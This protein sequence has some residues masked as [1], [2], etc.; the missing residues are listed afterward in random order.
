MAKKSN[1]KGSSVVIPWEIVEQDFKDMNEKLG[2]NNIKVKQAP[3]LIISAMCNSHIRALHCHS[4]NTEWLA[5]CK[6][7]P[8]WDWV[9]KL[10]DMIHPEQKTQAA[11]CEP[12]DDW[13]NW[14]V[15][16]LLEQKEKLWQWNCILHSHHHM[17]CFWSGTD[18]DARLGYNDWRNLMWAVV[19]AYDWEPETWN[20]KY[21]GCV[22]F[23]K[24]YNVEID[25]EI[26][27][28]E[29][30]YYK[31]C[32]EYDKSDSIKAKEIKELADS[33][34]EE[35]LWSQ[36]EALDNL[37]VKP[38]Y[39]KILDYLWID[40]TEELEENYKEV[41]K[42][43]PNK[44]LA[45]FYDGLYKEAYKTAE[46][47]IWNT[48]ATI[49]D[50][51]LEWKEWSDALIK[52]LDDHKKVEAY[53]YYWYKREKKDNKTVKTTQEPLIKSSYNYDYDDTYY[54][55]NDG[56]F[57]YNTYN[58]PTKEILKEKLGIP[59]SIWVYPDKDWTWI[60]Y[61]PSNKKR[62]PVDDCLD[63]LFDYQL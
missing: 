4:P 35:N 7:V 49:S 34:F 51:A 18:N 1:V 41:Q 47:A 43:M 33:I 39:S 59:A 8:V 62:E 46:E 25:V 26:E 30:D 29:W 55:V 50:E 60:A 53:W 42:K 58:Y 63:D 2:L 9:F 54:N 61:N 57:F 12:T 13:L 40:I 31:E 24:P 37:D 28:E 44:K 56:W 45:E 20:V 5:L 23:Y 11:E 21:K 6:I 3:K 15:D 27:V 52:Q 16:Y 38:D 36:K 10:V 19:T 22:N 17:G 14:A 32:D 48:P